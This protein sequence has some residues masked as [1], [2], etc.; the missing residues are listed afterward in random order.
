MT[1]LRRP[2]LLAVLLSLVAVTAVAITVPAVIRI[3]RTAPE[4]RPPGLAAM[5]GTALATLL[6]TRDD[7]PAEWE[8]NYTLKPSD[9]FGYASGTPSSPF[10]HPAECFALIAQANA[11]NN[12]FAAGIVGH[13][14]ADPEV[15]FGRK[16]VRIAISRDF[17]PA[18][19][20]QH[21]ALL[22]RCADFTDES[23]NPVA[24]ETVKI[25]ESPAR[26]QRLRYSLTRTVDGEPADQAQTDYY[27]LVQLSGLVLAGHASTDHQLIMDALFETTLQRIRAR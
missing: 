24:H 8:V 27:S 10:Y 13:D 18:S 26:Q 21:V 25:L 5:N 19:F 1:A 14:P 23:S 16:D 12:F 7:F 17:H 9:Q 22:S 6:P 15:F 20:D 11:D 4:P 3:G 2:R